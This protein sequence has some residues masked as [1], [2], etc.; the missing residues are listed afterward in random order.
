MN[1]CLQ[2]SIRKGEGWVHRLNPW[3]ALAVVGILALTLG[4]SQAMAANQVPFLYSPLSPGS[5]APGSKTFTLTVN[6]TGFVSGAT[7]YWN[8]ATLT[9][10]FVTSSQLTASVPAANVATAGT[11]TITVQNPGTIASNPVHFQIQKDSYTVAYGTSNYATDTTPQDIATASFRNDGYYD[12]AVATGNNTV[13]ILLGNG[14]GSF[15]THV[16]YSV[17]GNPVAIIV[18]DFNGDGIP[19][20]ATA[21]QYT[22]QVSILL[23][24]GD[25]TF[26]AHQEYATGPEPAALAAGDFNGDG[27]LDLAVVD[28]N[29]GQVSILLGNGNGTFQNHV[30]YSVGSN[31]VGVAIADYNADGKLDLAVANN[32]GNTVSILLGNGDGTFQTQVTYATAE[33][34]TAIA[35]GELHGGGIVDLAVCTSNKAASVLLGNGNGTFQNH[36]DYGIG[37]DAFVIA[38]ADLASTGNLDIVTGNYADNTVSVLVGNGNGTFKSQDVFPSG[39]TPSGIAIADYNNDGRLDVAVAAGSANAAGVLLDGS[40]ILSPGAVSFG[41]Q[42]SGEKS[43]AKTVTLTN[44]GSTTYTL[45]TISTVGT[46]PTDYTQT[47]TCG[48]TIAAG[49]TCTFTNYFT[50][51]ACEYANSQLLITNGS[52]SVG[53]QMTGTGNIPL[54]LSPRTMNFNTYQLIGTTSSP[55]TET[56]TND[57]GVNIVFS[58][59]DLEGVN[60]TE[61]AN[62]APSTGAYCLTL[63]NSTLAPGASCETSVVFAPTQSGGANVTQVYYGNFCLAKQGLLI[64][65]LGTAVNVTPT[66]ITFPSTAVG[67]T[68]TKTVTFQNAGS[69]AL[70]ISSATLTGTSPVFSIQSNTCGFVQGTG[71]SV[72]ANSSCTFTLGFTPTASG[73][74]TGTFSI[75]D[76]DPTGPQQVKLAGTGTT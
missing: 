64:S 13:S 41:T 44:Q 20:I 10:T 30:E 67:N 5:K 72:P 32:G 27:I 63:P 39:A 22:S 68:S 38:L 23:G 49:K 61:F 75:G 11:A 46:D 47:N 2:R 15:P 7:V 16:Q 66:S 56:F 55:K 60:Q 34:P 18:G 54:T 25:G 24:N 58:L 31:P 26:Q 12:L 40:L 65:G 42:T 51:T 35:A 4:A 33:N 69:T 36:V 52:S 73:T 9:T 6:G 28:G 71:G 50:P 57:S 21:D 29:S 45:G 8:G 53:Y 3:L 14:T 48:A 59:I 76:P 70:A 1:N 19:D 74:Q 37:A 62:Q 17:P 43:A